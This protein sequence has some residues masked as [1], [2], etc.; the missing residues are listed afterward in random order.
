MSL[1]AAETAHRIEVVV[2]HGSVQGAAEELG[3]NRQSLNHFILKYEKRTGRRIPRL[4]EKQHGRHLSDAEIERRFG[5]IDGHTTR[6]AADALGLSVV[7][8]W[9]WI[10]RC[11]YNGYRVPNPI[12]VKAVKNHLRTGEAAACF[13]SHRSEKRAME[14][15]RL[16]DQVTAAETRPENA[17]GITAAW[18]ALSEFRRREWPGK[19]PGSVEDLRKEAMRL[20]SDS[21]SPDNPFSDPEF[22][23]KFFDGRL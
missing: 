1:S 16:L 6:E 13:I 2:R 9:A 8:I 15:L 12:R 17:E 23:A 20:L 4:R 19:W 7:R 18:H 10:G 3:V 21:G 14:L 22:V 5:A 11:R